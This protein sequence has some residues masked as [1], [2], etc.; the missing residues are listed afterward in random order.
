MNTMADWHIAAQGC[1]QS[2]IVIATI[3]AT[4][5]EEA[6][7]YGFN[8]TE[9]PVV[10]TE[11]QLLP[12]IAKVAKDCPSLKS[13]IYSGEKPAGIEL[14]EGIT[15]YAFEDIVKM[16]GENN[17]Q[18]LTPPAKDDIAVIMYTSGSTGLPKGVML[19]HYN[20]VTTMI[21][22]KHGLPSVV[23]GEDCFIGFLPLAHIFA[24][25][26]EMFLLSQ[27]CMIGYGSALTLTDTSPK[28]KFGT[29]GD[30]SELR[31]TYMAAVPTIMDRIRQAVTGK[32]AAGSTIVQKLFN[33]AFKSKNEA[34]SH[35]KHTPIW[36][37]IVFNKIKIVLGGNIKAIF[38]GGAPLAA[39]SQ[40]FM[41]VVFGV[42]V[43]QG[44]G[45]TETCSAGTVAS[46]SDL[47]SYGKVGGP[48]SSINLKMVDWEEGNYRVAD[49]KNK[50]I[51]M[52]RGE[53]VLGGGSI[54]QGYY[55][56]PDRTAEEFKP[57]EN[58]KIW[59]HTGD[60]GQMHPDGTL[61]IIDRKKDLVKLQQGEY[62]S[63][64]KVESML[65]A[66]NYID[67]MCVYAD[68]F[69]S[70]CIAIV[71]VLSP[72]V[73][74]WAQK[75]GCAGSSFEETCKDLKVVAEVL[76]SLQDEA[77][78]NK[79]ARFETP[80]KVYVEPETWLP[81]GGL[82]TASLKLQRNKINQHYKPEIEKMLE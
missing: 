37:A 31:P 50:N 12:A 48:F 75:N 24:L 63:L 60:I 66:A 1:F 58:G 56:M 42:P 44:Y 77:K 29:K 57:D 52:P 64:G 18:E 80:A 22:F 68:P 25:C 79:L 4:L 70:Y 34:Y 35:G 47:N 55:R 28:I 5:G 6:L 3:Y 59:F 19:T 76:R 26:A 15:L 27:G 41:N 23:P 20:V 46:T 33:R 49:L 67:N 82:V 71:T 65:K 36:D 72:A 38:S 17:D 30:I 10:I 7:A 13:I 32:V 39:D 51:G 11:G 81:E 8:Q 54:S 43:C 9:T 40:R 14:P 21:G 16:G 2:N 45:L 69:H 61:Q 73:S 78:K 62:V 74:E 53:I